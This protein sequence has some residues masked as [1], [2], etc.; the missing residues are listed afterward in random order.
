MRLTVDDFNLQANRIIVRAGKNEKYREV[1]L[2]PSVR[3]AFLKYLP[4]R[5][6]LIEK[7]NKNTKALIVNQYG[8]SITDDGGHNVI[9]RIAKRA[10]IEFSPH[11]ARRFYGS[12][13]WD[14]DLK[15]EL[16][17]QL[18][19]LT[20]VGTTM[21]YIQPDAEDTF[22]EV[23]MNMKKLDFN[24]SQRKGLKETG[25]CNLNYIVCSGRDLDPSRGIES[26]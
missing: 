26:P 19:G 7:T 21:I 1:S 20:S 5:Q 18:L 4:F 8:R 25:E 17:Q 24:D 14:N 2:F 12:H 11:R 15:P 3:E 22:S 16:I 13:L 9:D 10:G 23:N 6:A